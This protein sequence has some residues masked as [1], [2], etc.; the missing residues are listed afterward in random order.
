MQ[1]RALVPQADASHYS[2]L[3]AKITQIK[4][5]N[6]SSVVK[7]TRP[8]FHFHSKNTKLETVSNNFKTPGTKVV[9]N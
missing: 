2:H 5:D 3:V 6:Q 1:K 4:S 9:K 8:Y 7:Y